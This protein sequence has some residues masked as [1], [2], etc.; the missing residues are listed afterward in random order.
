M[1]TSNAVDKLYSLISLPESP[2]TYILVPSLL[3]TTSLGVKS[4]V[5]IEKFCTYVAVEISYAPFTLTVLVG[6]RVTLI[7][8]ESAQIEDEVTYFTA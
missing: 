3:K 2:T 4:S 1:D 5:A 8:V 6:V 7:V